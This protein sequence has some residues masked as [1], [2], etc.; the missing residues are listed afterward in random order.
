M[1]G[2]AVAE[3]GFGGVARPAA[4][5]HSRHTAAPHIVAAAGG[6]GYFWESRPLL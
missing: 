1:V 6:R 4:F 2:L 3:R 5:C